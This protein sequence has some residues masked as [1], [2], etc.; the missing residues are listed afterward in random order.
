MESVRRQ[1]RTACKKRSKISPTV[2]LVVLLQLHLCCQWQCVIFHQEPVLLCLCLVCVGLFRPVRRC[3]WPLLFVSFCMC[4]FWYDSNWRTASSSSVTKLSKFQRWL[5]NNTLTQKS[6][7]NLLWL[8]VR[9]DKAAIVPEPK[10]LPSFCVARSDGF[11]LPVSTLHAQLFLNHLRVTLQ[12][13]KLR[14]LFFFPLLNKPSV[15]CKP[16]ITWHKKSG[17]SPAHAHGITLC[18]LQHD[19][20]IL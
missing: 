14:I 10:D 5:T 7:I 6:K 20:K 2:S 11:D 4:S 17:A 16:G 3:C 15:V 1:M 19:Q 8:F 9:T 13:W 12:H 18:A